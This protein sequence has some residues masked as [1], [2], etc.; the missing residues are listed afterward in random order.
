MQS[1]HL[2]CVFQGAYFCVLRSKHD[3]PLYQVETSL[4]KRDYWA[5]VASML[6]LSTMQ[7]GL[8][9]LTFITR[10]QASLQLLVHWH[11]LSSSLMS[12]MRWLLP[13]VGATVRG[14]AGVAWLLS[15]LMKCQAAL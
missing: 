4:P 2:C 14:V 10:L 6:F 7:S 12:W 1:R 3:R 8:L 13:G 9:L 5:K 15:L 11:H